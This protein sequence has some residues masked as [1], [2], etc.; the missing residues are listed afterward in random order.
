MSL[1]G[2]FTSNPFRLCL[3]IEGTVLPGHPKRA[4]VEERCLSRIRNNFQTL[5]VQVWRHCEQRICSQNKK[6]RIFHVTNTHDWNAS[7]RINI[8]V[9]SPTHNILELS[10]LTILPFFGPT[11]HGSGP[12]SKDIDGGAVNSSLQRRELIRIS[13]RCNCLTRV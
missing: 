2:S 6:M 4:L 9:V 10:S 11:F 13:K 3:Q 12:L 7:G 8:N 1:L 5:V